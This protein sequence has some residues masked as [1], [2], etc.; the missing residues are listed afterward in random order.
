MSD[1]GA[2]KRVD[3]TI[4]QAR[5]TI[6]SRKSGLKSRG[7]GKGEGMDHAWPINRTINDPFFRV[8]TRKKN[9]SSIRSYGT[10]WKL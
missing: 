3:L 6:E 2:R 4:F 5:S 10:L 8:E 1:E 7:E 9:S